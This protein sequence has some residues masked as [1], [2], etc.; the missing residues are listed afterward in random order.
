VVATTGVAS[1][2]PLVR[3]AQGRRLVLSAGVALIVLGGGFFAAGPVLRALPFWCSGPAC[4]PIQHIVIIVKENRSFDNLYGRFP[5]ADGTEYAR[6][7]NRVIKMLITPDHFPF[8]L[9]HG[10]VS[11][12]TAMNYGQMNE[13]VKGE[14]AIQT[15]N[16]RREDVAD[17]QL[18]KASIPSYWAYARAFSLADH[19]F[20]TIAASSFPNHLT[21]VDGNALRVVDNPYH[22]AGGYP[23]LWKNPKIRGSSGANAYSWGCDAQKGTLVDTMTNGISRAITPCFTGRTLVDEA[24]AAG[25]SWKYYSAAP[26]TFGYVWNTLDA[27]RHVRYSSQWGA[28]VSTPSGFDR[29]VRDGKLPAISWLTPPF[30]GS[31]HPPA[32]ECQGEDWTLFQIN[33]IMQSAEWK[34][35]VIILTWD[36]YGGFYDHVRPPGAPGFYA[37]SLG[38]RVPTLVISPYAKPHLIYHGQLDFRSIMK[39]A[40]T[41]FDLPHLMPYNRSVT[42]IGQMLDTRQKPNPPLVLQPRACPNVHIDTSGVY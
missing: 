37:G 39:F 2:R 29:D 12:K 17:S 40:E 15:V 25:V 36:D 34:H 16:G 5:G 26:G 28:N 24:K 21:L 8:D 11:T 7:G 14:N 1:R 22:S 33:Q 6:I 38:P 10:D 27:F 32:S 13:F 42:S 19:F 30:K 35:T 20:S 41:Q 3:R 31:D 18:D 4:G 9:G 23:P